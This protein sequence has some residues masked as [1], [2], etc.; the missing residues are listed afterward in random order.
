MILEH[1]EAPHVQ[2]TQHWS[3]VFAGFDHKRRHLTG[4]SHYPRFLAM[5]INLWNPQVKVS[6]FMLSRSCVW[7]HFLQLCGGSLE[8]GCQSLHLN[9]HG[10]PS[11][12]P[13]LPVFLHPCTY[14]HGFHV[15]SS[16]LPN[17]MK[18]YSITEPK[19][20][21]SGYLHPVDHC[22]SICSASFFSPQSK[23]LFWRKKTLFSGVWSK[24][25][26]I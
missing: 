7:P 18:L 4:T 2:N 16:K 22:K 21:G 3:L 25:Y 6:K 13:L 26:A 20:S 12:E 15:Q 8:V 9:I 5:Y 24:A 1:L 14:F 23:N 17:L 11:N 10:H 19:A